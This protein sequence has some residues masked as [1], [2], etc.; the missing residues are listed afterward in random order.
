MQGI[1]PAIFC[2]VLSDIVIIDN[3]TTPKKKSK[4]ADSEGKAVDAANNNNEGD[5]AKQSEAKTNSISV[6]QDPIVTNEILDD[7]SM[8]K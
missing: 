4:G 3:R 2:L 5:E 6:A 1:V 7:P 8:N